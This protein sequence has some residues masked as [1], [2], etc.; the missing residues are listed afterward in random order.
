MHELTQ[1]SSPST[2]CSKPLDTLR[3]FYNFLH[4]YFKFSL[5][6][7]FFRKGFIG[8][9]HSFLPLP[10]DTMTEWNMRSTRTSTTQPINISA[11]PDE[12][13]DSG[14]GYPNRFDDDNHLDVEFNNLTVGSLPSIRRERRLIVSSGNHEFIS[15]G[16]TNAGQ[17][18]PSLYRRRHSGTSFRNA[19]ST[20][21]RRR[22][23][24]DS[25]MIHQMRIANSMPVPSAPFLAS[26]NDQASGDRLSRYVH[27][28]IHYC[29]ISSI[30]IYQFK[31]FYFR[32]LSLFFLFFF[33]VSSLKVYQIWR[34][35]KV[36]VNPFH[37]SQC[38][39]VH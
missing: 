33:L 5:Q 37:P 32:I 28:H 27:V 17:R 25:S 4:R 9:D 7:C 2:C 1:T 6:N 3:F 21:N 12:Y 20:S 19:I 18:S 29:S 10:F 14:V 39:M 38:H 8:V 26:K 24:S 34:Y 13:G 36:L 22:Q 31:S 11:S 16:T 30:M 23:H 15:N 35:P